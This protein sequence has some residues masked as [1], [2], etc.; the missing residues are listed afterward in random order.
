ML[1]NAITLLATW[2][3]STSVAPLTVFSLLNGVANGAFFTAIPTVFS[4][5]FNPS[6]GTMVV[7]T[8]T[9]GWTLGYLLVTPIAGYLLQSSRSGRI[10]FSSYR[11]AIFYVGGVGV[12]TCAFAMLARISFNKA[13]IKRA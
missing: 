9:T 8:G 2:P 7:S 4:G 11:P 13:L 1:L 12:L 3:L 6:Q 10:L 5:F